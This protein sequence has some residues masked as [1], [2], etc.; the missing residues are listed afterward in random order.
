MSMEE[1]RNSAALRL[2]MWILSKRSWRIKENKDKE[3]G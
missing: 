1:I 3:K 2:Q